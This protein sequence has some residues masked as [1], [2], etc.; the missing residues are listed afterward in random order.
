MSDILNKIFCCD[1]LNNFYKN[2]CCCFCGETP[3]NNEYKTFF[4][5]PITYKIFSEF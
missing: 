3:E 1:Q 4:N 5:N 2:F